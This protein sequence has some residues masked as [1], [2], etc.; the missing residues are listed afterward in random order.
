LRLIYSIFA[1]ILGT[2]I[3]SF[4]NVLIYRL[5]RGISIIKPGSFCPHCKKPIR[6]Y[7]NIPILSFIL[8]GGRCSN[9]EKPISWQYPTV[10][11]LSGLFFLWS[12]VKFKISLNLFFILI[13]FALLIAISG[14][15]F[16]YQLIPDALSIPGI[17]SGLAF[18][19]LNKNFYSG[20][21]GMLFGGGLIF[22]IRVLG[23]RVY[24]KEVMGLGDVYLT[25]MIGAYI[26]FPMIIPGIFLAALSGS[27]FGIIYLVAAHK[28]K[29]NPIPFG[30]FLSLGGILI[31]LF[32]SF[33]VGVL[34]RLGIY[35]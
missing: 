15:D 23:N 33:I 10:E 9:C 28:S 14:I 1:F 30:P 26:G 2:A 20:L 4:I 21:I 32:Q 35:L 24:K 16:T 34:S 6:W 8:L 11:L 17:I 22:L 12:F 19:I 5:P 13:F 3:G 27:I 18:Q 25:A 29:E 7:E 31:I